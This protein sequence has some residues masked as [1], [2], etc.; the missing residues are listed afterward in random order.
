M[1]V[2]LAQC[3]AQGSTLTK[4]ALASTANMLVKLAHAST[5]SLTKFACDRNSAHRQLPGKAP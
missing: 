3:F 4:F 5:A 1:L 2:K